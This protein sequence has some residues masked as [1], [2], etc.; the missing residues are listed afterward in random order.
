MKSNVA[1]IFF[2]G[3]DLGQIPPLDKV[4]K[5]ACPSVNYSSYSIESIAQQ[6]KRSSSLLP[7]K[8]NSKISVKEKHA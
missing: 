7:V 4:R 8:I 2:L 5:Q 3:F 6:K 1:R